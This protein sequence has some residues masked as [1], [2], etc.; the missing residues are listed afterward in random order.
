[1]GKL[2]KR[3]RHI[4]RLALNKRSKPDIEII[5]GADDQG[6]D[7]DHAPIDCCYDDDD[8][9]DD[10][11][12]EI[13]ITRTQFHL[14]WNQEARCRSR[15]PHHGNGRSSMFAKQKSKRER[16]E[17]VKRDRKITHWFKPQA[18]QQTEGLLV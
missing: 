3:G 5:S 15:K 16:E 12:Q 18:E 7:S 8:Y 6:G 10:W 14:E 2:G 17:N 9:I 4:R 11:I 1:M 13:D